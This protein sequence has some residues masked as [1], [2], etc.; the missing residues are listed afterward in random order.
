MEAEIV[1]LKTKSPKNVSGM[2]LSLTSSNSSESERVAQFRMRIRKIVEEEEQDEGEVASYSANPV[3]IQAGGVASY[4]PIYSPCAPRARILR[5][6]ANRR[7]RQHNLETQKDET[8]ADNGETQN[9]DANGCSCNEGGEDNGETQ[10]QESIDLF[11][12]MTDTRTEPI[13]QDSEPTEQTNSDISDKMEPESTPTT[14]NDTIPKWRI[15]TGQI[16]V[17]RGCKPFA[18]VLIMCLT[19]I[20]ASSAF[21]FVLLDNKYSSAY[22][23]NYIDPIASGLGK[24]YV[25]ISSRLRGSVLNLD[26]MCELR[27]S[28][29]KALRSVV[30]SSG[31]AFWYLRSCTSCILKETCIKSI[32]LVKKSVT[33]LEILGHHMVF[34][35]MAIA[36]EFRGF[37]KCFNNTMDYYKDFHGNSWTMQTYGHAETEDLYSK[38][39][40]EETE[41]FYSKSTHAET[42]DHQHHEHDDQRVRVEKNSSIETSDDSS[43]NPSTHQVTQADQKHFTPEHTSLVLVML[44]TPKP[45]APHTKPEL[46]KSSENAIW[47]HVKVVASVLILLLVL[48]V[49]G[50]VLSPCM[51]PLGSGNAQEMKKRKSRSPLAATVYE[52]PVNLGSVLQYV[53][54]PHNGEVT[55]F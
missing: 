50:A 25:N 52:S 39:T 13:V 6:R 17:P 51:R 48:I 53:D 24:T 31:S 49:L 14:Q 7:Q 54:Q 22:D 30:A 45:Q 19:L 33:S 8:K 44:P 2:N 37:C 21:G 55:S 1:E 29:K 40:H 42:E 4:H 27:N 46:D 47:N 38:S 5:A 3:I 34:S 26:F 12:K 9:P 10:N 35:T 32:N 15:L 36:E 23:G 20:S 16:S 41:D 43:S 18:M 28:S 11:D